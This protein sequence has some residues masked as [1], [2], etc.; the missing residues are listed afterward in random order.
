M[1]SFANKQPALHRELVI[2]ELVIQ[3]LREME[4]TGNFD[5]NVLLW[6]QDGYA[7]KAIEENLPQLASMNK[8]LNASGASDAERRQR[9]VETLG[10]LT[11]ETYA[12]EKA[13]GR[14]V[15]LRT[16]V[17]AAKTF[18]EA[19]SARY[20]AHLGDVAEYIKK[21]LEN[22]EKP[23]LERFARQAYISLA[24]MSGA[25]SNLEGLSGKPAAQAV[26]LQMRQGI[27]RI[28]Y[29]TVADQPVQVGRELLKIVELIGRD[30]EKYI[31]FRDPSR[32]AMPE[33]QPWDFE[34]VPR[35]EYS[36]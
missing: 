15:D 3:D 8:A 36:M 9:R 1:S 22:G 4:R 6:V 20:G 35:E 31:E 14:G 16:Y 23:D 2:G 10:Q 21:A 34:P 11:R 7:N 32:M 24:K 12:T 29:V 28:N 26:A 33:R 30:P 17:D 13:L 19:E 18:Y 25:V 5:R 27:E